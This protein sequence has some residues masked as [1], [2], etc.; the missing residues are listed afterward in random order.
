[1]EFLESNTKTFFISGIQ[2]AEI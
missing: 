1:M 2:E